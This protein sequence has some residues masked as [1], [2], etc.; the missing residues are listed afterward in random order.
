LITSAPARITSRTLRLTPS[1][2][3]HTPSGIPGY[4]IPHGAIAPLGSQASL[5]P[6]VIESMVTLICM[7]GPTRMPSSTAIRSPASAPEASR[8]VVMP[9]ARVVRSVSAIRK[10]ASENGSFI[11]RASSKSS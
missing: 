1:T 9:S 7:R 4:S 11:R 6:P 10:N 8:T 3:S 5:C 2:P